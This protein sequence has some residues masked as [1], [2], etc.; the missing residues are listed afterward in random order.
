MTGGVYK[1]TNQVNRRFYVGS[2]SLFDERWKSHKQMLAT[3][4]HTNALLQS[5][6][7]EFGLDKF[8]FEI[9]E[10]IKNFNKSKEREKFWIKNSDQSLLYNKKGVFSL[11]RQQ[12]ILD[13]LKEMAVKNSLKLTN[14]MIAKE[15]FTRKKM[16]GF[17]N[18]PIDVSA[19]SRYLKV[20]KQRGLLELEQGATNRDRIINLT[21]EKK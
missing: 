3:K 5:D 6:C 18:K 21:G 14:A 2:A 12:I 17:N 15:L 10:V 19:V 9:V 7:N 20:L 11:T 1:I 8:C 13:L 4:S 16:S